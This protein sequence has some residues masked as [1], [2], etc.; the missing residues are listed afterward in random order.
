MT[1]SR[2]MI[3]TSKIPLH[4]VGTQASYTTSTTSQRPNA[5]DYEFSSP[6]ILPPASLSPPTR[7]I[8]VQTTV[9]IDED[10]EDFKSLY[11]LTHTKMGAP[12]NKGLQ[13]LF[14][15]S[16]FTYGYAFATVFPESKVFSSICLYVETHVFSYFLMRFSF[17][18]LILSSIKHRI[19]LLAKICKSISCVPQKVLDFTNCLYFYTSIRN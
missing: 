5:I 19:F 1:T 10:V 12:R 2:P 7:V 4:T 13:C 16:R 18:S 3:L 8:P 11:N 17:F 14:V 9:V 15:K 6:G